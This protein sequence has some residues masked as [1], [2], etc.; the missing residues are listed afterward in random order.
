MSMAPAATKLFVFFS[1]IICFNTAG[2]QVTEDTTFKTGGKLWGYT[3]GDYYYKAHSDELNR[4]GVNQYTGIEKGR[5]A[6]QIRRAYVGYNYEITRKFA[7]ELLLAAEDN[8]TG[9]TG[10]PTGDLLANGKFSFFLKYA[11]LRWR[12]IWRGADFIIG[13]VATPTYSLIEEPTW[14]HRFI[15]RTIADIRRTTSFDLGVALQGKFDPETANFGYNVMIGNG[16]GARPENDKFKWF[17]G[18]VYAK[19]FDKKLLLSLYADY[20]RLHRLDT[21]HHSRNMVKGFVAYT[22]PAITVGVEAFINHGKNDVVGIATAGQDTLDAH[23]RGISAFVRGPIIKDKV[24]FFAR[25][26]YYNPNHDYDN[27][28]Y[29]TY[30][31]F[32]APYE[33]NNKEH[34]VTAG[35]DF[36]PIKNVHFAPNV[37]YNNYKGQQTGLTGAAKKDYDLVYRLTFY[38]VYGR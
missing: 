16:T 1:A 32:T 10:V 6:F 7:A 38:Y 28:R 4:G 18:N 31:G 19:L 21:F 26:D 11:N 8:V 37:W 24:G 36:T 20:V 34:F 35:L 29:D 17:Y 23:A 14:G 27:G 30:K 3:F 33:P 2:A 25:M 12:N 22:I 13:L 5:N 15:E 9:S